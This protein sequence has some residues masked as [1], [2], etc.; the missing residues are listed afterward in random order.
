[1][2]EEKK[3]YIGAPPNNH[4]HRKV[5][6]AVTTTTKQ[7]QGSDGLVNVTTTVRTVEYE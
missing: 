2:T 5:T 1:V 7:T 3:N 6:E 4:T